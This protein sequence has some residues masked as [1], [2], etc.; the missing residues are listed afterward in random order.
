MLVITQETK[1][2][3]D[4]LKKGRVKAYDAKLLK[5]NIVYAQQLTDMRIQNLY[6]LIVLNISESIPSTCKL[7]L[8]NTYIV[9][10]I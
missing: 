3:C 7:N 6:K 5:T 9:T 4:D 8:C 2:S 1:F 10:Y